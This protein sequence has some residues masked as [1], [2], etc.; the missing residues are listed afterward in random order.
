MREHFFVPRGVQIQ[1]SATATT[2]ATPPLTTVAF[3]TEQFA[4][5]VPEG[6][7]PILEQTEAGAEQDMPG[8]T[9]C[10][11]TCERGYAHGFI[12]KLLEQG[13][14][15]SWECELGCGFEHEHKAV[16]EKHERSCTAGMAKRPGEDPEEISEPEELKGEEV[17]TEEDQ[18][19]PML[20]AVSPEFQQ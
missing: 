6:D 7:I 17:E 16:T 14:K 20:S 5:A 4:L 18:E 1:T 13:Y 15:A 10:N 2:A 8:N 12:S 19:V 3:N 11:E 9:T